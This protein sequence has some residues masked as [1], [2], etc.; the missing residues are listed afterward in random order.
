MMYLLSRIM[1]ELKYYYYY[2]LR[3]W[4]LKS[5]FEISVVYQLDMVSVV[6]VSNNTIL[7]P[8]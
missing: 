7:C 4:Q 5:V 8:D 6:S 1:E 3:P 2:F